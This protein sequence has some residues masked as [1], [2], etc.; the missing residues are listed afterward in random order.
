MTRANHFGRSAVVRA[1]VVAAVF[2]LTVSA[3]G[4]RAGQAGAPASASPASAA[5]TTRGTGDCVVLGALTPVIVPPLEVRDLGDGTRR[6]TS[7]EGGYS[8]VVPGDWLISGASGG[9]IEPAYAQAHMSSYDLRTTPTGGGEAGS[10]LPPGIGIRFDIELWA[11]L[12]NEPADVFATRVLIGPDQHAALPGSFVDVNGRRAYRTTIQDERKFQP[13]SGP[14]IVA[15]QTRPVWLV[16]SPRAD[17]MIVL[18]AT[19]GESPLIGLVERAV[20]TLQ[21]TTPASS[22]LPVAK[23]R[24]DILAQWLVGKSGPIAGRRAEAK[25]MTYRESAV[26]VHG[27]QQGLNALTPMGILRIDRDPDELSWLVAVSGP[28][29]PQ[30][31]GAGRFGTPLLTQWILYNAPATQGRYSGGTGASYASAGAWPAHFDAL[32]DRCH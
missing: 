1:L 6:V 30:G 27:P 15:R 19:P 14:L 4:E 16:P 18:Y 10:I 22:V 20:S 25:L 31:R 9:G 28:D 12:A 8:I 2:A 29:L 5:A 3:C 23:Q 24:S 11:N 13:A 32:P 21:V 7:A 26:A 17:R